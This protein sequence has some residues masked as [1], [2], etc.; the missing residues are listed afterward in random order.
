ESYCEDS[1]GTSPA[2]SS[3]PPYSNLSS[4]SFSKS[5]P[6]RLSST[7]ESSRYFYIP[8]RK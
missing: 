4:L 3:S 1:S 7:S 2:T 5:L 8:L 6:H